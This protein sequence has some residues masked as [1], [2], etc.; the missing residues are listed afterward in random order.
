MQVFVQIFVE[1]FIQAW[2]QLN[3]N[4][5]RTFLSLLGISIGIWCVVSVTSAIDSLAENIKDSFK[6]LGDDVVYVSVIPFGEALTQEDI[7]RFLKRPFADNAEMLQIEDNAEAAEMAAYYA[8]MGQSTTKWRSSTVSNV[9]TIACT[10][11]Y[12]EIFNLE[13]E[14]GRFFTPFEMQHGDPKIVLGHNVAEKLFGEGVEPVGKFIGILG[15]KLEVIG[16]V[17]KEG[18]SLFNPVNFDDVALMSF[19]TV[20]KS[21]NLKKIRA[22]AV[23]VKAAK[24]ASIDEL[25]DDITWILRNKRRLKPREENNFALNN[26]SLI[27][28]AL[29]TLFGILRNAGFIIGIFS[30]LV[31]AFGVANIMF[32][33]VKERTS[34]IGIKK[35]LGAQRFVILTEFLIEAIVL[36]LMGGAVGLGL[37]YLSTFLASYFFGYDISLSFRNIFTGVSVSLIIGAVAGIIPAWRASRMDPVEAIRQ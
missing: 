28:K 20:S 34:I 18:K 29:D 10:D 26:L 9:F 5:L 30:L 21:Y 37:V 3:A 33:S 4:R 11:H 35:A 2:G 1:S 23:C 6:K 15:W 31:G 36:C 17:K 7:D 32:V 24:G 12:A 27:E 13:F 16:V 22:G 19:K 8:I 25:K 14:N